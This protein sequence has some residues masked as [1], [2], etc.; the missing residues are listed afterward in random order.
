MPR[1]ESYGQQRIGT[2]AIAG[3]KKQS[4]LTPDSLGAGFGE[5]LQRVGVMALQEVERQK[6][7]ERQRADQLAELTAERQF[8]Q[9]DTVY[10]HSTDRGALNKTGKEPM[11]LR[12]QYQSEWDTSADEILKAAKTPE[13]ELALTRLRDR[14][15][16]SFVD[17][18]D[19][20]ASN[21]FGQYEIGEVNATLESSV[22]T[23][24]RAANL[25]EGERVPAV[26]EQLE[27]Q[28]KTV[29]RYADR[30]KLG[31][32]A[33]KQLTEK[34]TSSTHAGVIEQMIA[35]QQD[36]TA[37][38][39]FAE[40]KD[41][42]SPAQRA[43]LQVK[44]ENGSRDAKAFAAAD[45]IWSKHAPDP[46]D[47]ISAISLDKMEAAARTQFANDPK[48]YKLTVQYIRE[49]K[50]GIDDARRERKNV[51]DSSLWSAVASQQPLSKVRAM[52]EFRL[53][54]G[55]TQQQIVEYYRADADRDEARAASRDAR[56]ERARARA[57]QAKEDA[58]WSKYFELSDPAKLRSM[59]RGEILSQLP[60]LG[61]DHTNRLVN[62]WEQLQANDAK[63]RDATIDR[64]LFQEVASG[65]G[66]D[67]AYQ[68]PG[69][70]TQTQR[71]TL[72]R[73]QS[74]V[75]AE[76]ARHQAATGKQLDRDAKKA[77]MQQIVDTKVMVDRTLLP[78]YEAIAATVDEN[79]RGDAYV[80]IAKIQQT[81]KDGLKRMVNY[82][83]G[84]PSSVL[85][86]G[87]PPSDEQVVLR[88][89]DRIQRAYGRALLGGSDKEVNAI[90]EGKED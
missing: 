69:Q 8:N 88:F 43:D 16:A 77:L 83:R 38:E 49:K 78:D 60:T 74:A 72:G 12:K 63:V 79:A 50:Q 47:D 14:R 29:E 6:A 76:I 31:P 40:V 90:L 33:G 11:D 66:L 84:L 82:L 28:R 34:L 21:E 75:E 71:A 44:L 85:S 13:Q 67:Y 56:S 39:Y 5:Q 23:A 18:Y 45:D 22:A 9:L 86:F 17:R 42:I 27:L 65:A 36:L 62:D 61:R 87:P 4:V 51:V 26:A 25:P 54:P 81:N 52:P 80:P 64:D 55:E 57:E 1:V 46:G 58:G 32:E 10:L 59:N 7:L 30:L 68:T 89:Q 73:L 20:H 24:A 41:Q 53:A 70:Q 15:R 3:V 19:T 2:D 35:N 37:E 48:S